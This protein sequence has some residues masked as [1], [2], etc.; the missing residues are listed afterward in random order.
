MRKIILMIGSALLA[1][2]G[3]NAQ[4]T[5]T[6]ETSVPRIGD[7]F[8]YHVMEVENLDIT[9]GGENR[10]WDVSDVGD[11]ILSEIRYIDV[12]ES[13]EP[14]TQANI[15]RISEDEGIYAEGYY[16]SSSDGFVN[17][18]TIINADGKRTDSYTDAMD[19]LKFPLTYDEEYY[20]TFAGTI[21]FENWVQ[22]VDIEGTV[23]IEADGYGKL[24]LPSGTVDNVLRV[25]L[26]CD[27]YMDIESVPFQIETDTMYLW[28]N[29]NTRN[30]I[31]QYSV[32]YG[33]TTGWGMEKL[34]DVFQYLSQDDIIV[35]GIKDATSDNSLSIYPN[36]TRGIIHVAGKNE[37]SD[38][39]VYNID[40]ALLQQEKLPVINISGYPAGLYL[41]EVAGK[42]Y[43]VVK[44]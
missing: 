23:K 38:V 34:V 10:E 35:S 28:Y 3:M 8:H 40:G 33:D 9:F 16:T 41:I 4:I 39:K 6:S 43:K 20:E 37:I 5:L 21:T 12:A 26:V 1:V 24:K 27:V 36:P 32:V 30:V 29:A 44:E 42:K 17:N 22:T 14:S 13:S 18:K 31:A 11:G 15:V 7:V 19:L 25:K 2:S